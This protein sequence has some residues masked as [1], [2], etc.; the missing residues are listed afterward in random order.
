MAESENEKMKKKIEL[1]NTVDIEQIETENKNIK[2]Q[3]EKLTQES[4]IAK[5]AK[6]EIDEEI[7]KN[8]YLIENI[9][10]ENRRLKDEHRYEHSSL[11]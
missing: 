10:T 8:K 6:L 3:I 1:S 7:T 4:E 2:K 5:I 11:V 9:Q